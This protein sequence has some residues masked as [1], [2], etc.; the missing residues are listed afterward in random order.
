MF[1]Y[2]PINLALDEMHLPCHSDYG[3]LFVHIVLVNAYKVNCEDTDYVPLKA[4]LLRKQI[5]GKHTE[6]IKD[7]LISIEAI[8][9]DGRYCPREKCLGYRLGPNYR[10]NWVG[11]IALKKKVLI[12]KRREWKP[13]LLTP[14]H[15]ALWQWLNK[16]EINYE[17]AAKLL[18]GEENISQKS[19]MLEKIAAKD[20]F[21]GVDERGRVYHNAACL[22]SKFRPYLSIG[23]ETLVNVDIKN[24]QPLI[25]S[26]L[27]KKSISLSSFLPSNDAT[28]FVSLVETG[29]LYDFLME[30]VGIEDRSRFKKKFFAEIFYSRLGTETELS[31]QFSLLF[32]A[33]KKV[34]DYHKRNDYRD[35][36]L[37]MQ[38]LEAD[39]MIS[40]VCN[41]L[42]A[43]KTVPFLSVHDSI[44]TTA[45]H[46]EQV[47][48]IIKG[49]FSEV[50]LSPSFG[51]LG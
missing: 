29:K 38:R 22:W 13:T 35:L 46:A 27:L 3:R 31:R 18:I 39:L 48:D 20:W 41:K 14:V 49:T 8:E 34:I 51:S 12:K 11:R 36:P 50:G 24:S 2:N 33:V 16:L 30:E 10:K 19:L 21:F 17:E 25:F 28:F 5:H 23:K 9:C 1:I 15:E 32:P 26:V 43:L 7:A 4:T 44:L 45:R 37:E 47:K 40:G 42:H 6:A